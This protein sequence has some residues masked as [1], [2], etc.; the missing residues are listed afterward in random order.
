MNSNQ[1]TP[2]ANSSAMQAFRRGID[3][4]AY[5]L[6]RAQCGDN[7]LLQS[8]LSGVD[9]AFNAEYAE[10]PISQWPIRFWT[11]LLS[12]K[13]L[14]QGQSPWPALA[15]ISHGPRA[16]LLLR[17]V[18]GLDFSHAAQVLNISETTYRFA[19]ERGLEQL[20]TAGFNFQ[21]LERL[22][23]SFFE[24]VKQLPTELIQ[25]RERPAVIFTPA[26]PV[27]EPEPVI[28]KK[29][30]WPWLLLFM[31]LIV[32]GLSWWWWNQQTIEVASTKPVTLTDV[33]TAV[34]H[35]DYDVI[36]NPDIQTQTED[37][38]FLSWIAA[39]APEENFEVLKSGEIS[40]P[41]DSSV[42]DEENVEADDEN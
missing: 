2:A 11:L 20:H 29:S 3:R 36:A 42:L 25:T 31:A 18:A 33:Q 24:E 26:T 21:E 5:V 6:A 41:Q 14:A 39:G 10:L 9:A 34:I 8:A 32:A 38:A 35:P 28:E 37:L 19:L 4:R 16:A 7:D 15:S 23:D 1:I 30:Y 27:V 13:E 22:R 12:R 40:K 17:L